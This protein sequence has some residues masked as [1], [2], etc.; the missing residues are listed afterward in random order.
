MK[1]SRGARRDNLFNSVFSV[2][3][4]PTLICKKLFDVCANKLYQWKW[5]RITWRGPEE[6]LNLK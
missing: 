4:H 2:S 1:L 5:T 6:G 3:Q